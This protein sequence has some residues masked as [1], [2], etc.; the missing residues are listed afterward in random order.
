MR[1]TTGGSVYYGLLAAEIVAELLTPA[2][3]EDDLS[4]ESLAEYDRR[5]RSLLGREIEVG[6]RFRQLARPVDDGTLAFL[7][8]LASRDGV[9]RAIQSHRLFDWHSPCFPPSSTAPSPSSAPSDSRSH[10][11]FP[12]VPCDPG[13]AAL[14]LDVAV[15]CG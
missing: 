4:A 12:S 2:L 5:C 15:G 3:A 11:G 7:I 1:T 14:L 6:V 10:C 9:R 13:L 8:D